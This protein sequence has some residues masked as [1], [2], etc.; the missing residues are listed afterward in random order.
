MRLSNDEELNIRWSASPTEV[1]KQMRKKITEREGRV[2]ECASL[3]KCGNSLPKSSVVK[4]SS[5]SSHHTPLL[6]YARGLNKMIYR[7]GSELKGKKWNY[8][9]SYTSRGNVAENWGGKN[10]INDITNFPLL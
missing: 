7:R 9:D 8:L 6:I 4:K 5:S 10:E 3:D 1:S 2:R